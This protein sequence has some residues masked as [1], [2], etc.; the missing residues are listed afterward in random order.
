MNLHAL[1]AIAAKRTPEKVAL[2]FAYSAA[3]GTFATLTYAELHAAADRLASGLQ[4]W[5][6]AKGD[7]VAFFLGNR[8]EFVVAYLAVIKLGA[9]MVPVN[10][11]YRRLEIGHI[12][13]DCAPRLVITENEQL[14][15][16]EDAGYPSNGEIPL[17]VVEEID[18]WANDNPFTAP[19]ILAEDLALIM[20]TSGTTGRSKGAMLSHS[21]VLSTVVALLAAWD[22]QAQD[23]LLLCLPIFHVHGLVVGL[24]CALAAGATVLLRE[25]FVANE[26]LAEILSCQPTL[27]FAVPTI[28]VR[29]VEELRAL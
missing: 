26:T 18:A 10:L 23:T 6:L 19:L 2:Q 20:Y 25:K 16:L 24:H 8:P 9:I 1:F 14:P 5:G 3:P 29:L 21:N 22:W 15:Y 27:F 7:R 11:R 12:F 28:Y 4:R 13:T 17:L